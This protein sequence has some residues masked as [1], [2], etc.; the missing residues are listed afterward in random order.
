[1]PSSALPIR[2]RAL[3]AGVVAV[4]AAALLALA[5]SAPASAANPTGTVMVTTQRMSAATL[6]S[7]QLG[8]YGKGSKLTLSCSVSNGQAVKGYYSPWLPN[9]GWD[10]IWYKT[11]DGGYVAD[12]DLNTG[13]NA[14]VVGPCTNSPAPTSL[15]KKVD[16]FVQRYQN[17]YVDYDGRY[18]AQCVDL[19]NYY[20]RDVLGNGFVSVNYAYQLYAA[21]P[22]SRYTK[23]PASSTPQKGDVAI[24]S[25]QLPG[26]GG[27]GHVGI[28]TANVSSTKVTVFEQNAAGSASVVRT[29][30]KSHLLGYLRP[31]V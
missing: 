4:L 20:N 16:A 27:A 21:A 30:S 31:R 26:S 10:S 22:S 15:A 18:G 11:T 23:L 7:P 25:N 13:S 9:G 1:M 19:F 6:N 5:P 3:A 29:E 8:W 2:N 14:V 17:K 28:V 12:V 24:W